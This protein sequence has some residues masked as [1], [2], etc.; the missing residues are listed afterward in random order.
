TLDELAP[1]HVVTAEFDP[2]RDEG[3]AY[4]ERLASSGV[5]VEHRRVSGMIHGFMQYGSLVPE[6][7]TEIDLVGARLRKALA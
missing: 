4:A 7:M 1:A 2:L 6:V 5:P 3:D